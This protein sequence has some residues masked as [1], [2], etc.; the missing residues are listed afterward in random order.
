MYMIVGLGNPGIAYASSRHNTGFL[1]VDAIAEKL[2]VSVNIHARKGLMGK[3]IYEGETLLL[4]KPQT[5]MNLSGECV[6]AMTAFYKLPPENLIVI[7]DDIDLPVGELR[8]RSCGSAGTH[9]GMRSIV[10]CLGDDS[11]IRIRMGIGKQQGDLISHVMGTP[12]E[13][14][15]KLMAEAYEKAVEAALLIVSGKLEQAQ[16]RYNKKGRTRKKEEAPQEKEN[17]GENESQST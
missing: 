12:G 16:N 10:A 9:N 1:A 4:V 3:T 2:G 11:F 13:E 17:T 15:Q 6:Q 14:E 8:I 7:Y 5:Y